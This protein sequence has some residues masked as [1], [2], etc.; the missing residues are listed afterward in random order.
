LSDEKK[1]ALVEL[2]ARREIPLIEDDLFGD[3]SYD[4]ERPKVAKSYDRHGL[5]LLCSS[6]S[7]VLAPGFRVGWV[8]AGRFGR[9]VERLKFLTTLATA[10]LPQLVLAKFL[11]SGGYDRHL[12]S[13]RRAFNDHVQAM[14][15][16][17]A[18][19]FPPGTRITRPAGGYLLWVELPKN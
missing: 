3:L 8:E 11:E 4:L 6:F 15:R 13:L 16:A 14:S 1:K 19:Y 2:L 5:V 9:E 17:I 10:S 7:K 12:R 18:K